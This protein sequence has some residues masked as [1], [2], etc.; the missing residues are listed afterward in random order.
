[1]SK[2][3]KSMVD[4]MKEIRRSWTINPRTRV[5]SNGLKDKKKRRQTEKKLTGKDG[6]T[7]E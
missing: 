7:Y 5:Q 6:S 2:I 3:K 1:M 4:I